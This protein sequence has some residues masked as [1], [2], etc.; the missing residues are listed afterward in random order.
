MSE[1]ESDIRTQTVCRSHSLSLI[2]PP[3]NQK[4]DETNKN[5]VTTRKK[6]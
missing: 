3:S 2:S 1:S 4:R 6:E 5:A